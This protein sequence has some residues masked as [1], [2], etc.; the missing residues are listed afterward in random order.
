MVHK[1]HGMQMKWIGSADSKNI[2]LKA[3]D[4]RVGDVKQYSVVKMIKNSEC[5]INLMF[6]TFST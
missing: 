4:K 5:K 6:L 3:S 2:K 1:E